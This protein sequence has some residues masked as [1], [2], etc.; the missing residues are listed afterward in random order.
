MKHLTIIIHWRGPFVR[1]EINTSHGGNGLYLFGGKCRYERKGQLQYCGITET[2]YQ[3]RFREH[4]KLPKIT[5]DLEIW[6]GQVLYPNRVNR[7]TLEEAE[8]MMVYFWQP[9]LNE[10]KK[11]NPPKQPTSLISHWFKQDGSPRFRQVG[12]AGPLE[13]VLCWDGHFWRCGELRI[14]RA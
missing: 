14:K 2:S 11:V 5:R 13:D 7:R 8:R 1:E 4:H 9:P 3:K 12:L 6:L 10:R